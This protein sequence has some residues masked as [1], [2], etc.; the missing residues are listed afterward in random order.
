[1][2][3]VHYESK[4]TA[5]NSGLQK[6]HLNIGEVYITQTPTIV[7]TILGSCIAIVFYNR[8][9]QTGGIC[10]A[11]LPE[12]RTHYDSCKKT[13]P[14]RCTYKKTDRERFKYVT[15]AA[16]FMLEQ[17]YSFGIQKNEIDVKLFGGA[18]VFRAKDVS[19][20]I[21]TQNLKV[22]TDF[23][24]QHKLNL[25]SKHTGGNAGVTIYFHTHTGKVFLRRHVTINNT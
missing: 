9:L 18:N 22:A 11:Q 5:E 4:I 8:R 21:G 15:C 6:I 10:H 1:M 20:T 16:Q 23:I 12:K 17:F 3:I 14:I 25:I 19:K 13:C 7:W 24:Q 2:N